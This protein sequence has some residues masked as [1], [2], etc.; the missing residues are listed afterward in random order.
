MQRKLFL[1]IVVA[2]LS[3]SRPALSD[4][5]FS[6]EVVKVDEPSG[7]ITLK[8]AAIAQLGMNEADGTHSFRA[9]SDLMGGLIFNAL[10]PGDQIKFRAER[11]NGELALTE[12]EK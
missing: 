12:V 11:I 3:L 10:R 5:P 2:A 1:A 8:H 6:G 4:T 9:K 7:T